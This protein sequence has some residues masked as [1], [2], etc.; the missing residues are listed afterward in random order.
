MPLTTDHLLLGPHKCHGSAL[1]LPKDCRPS[2]HPKATPSPAA[3][4][5]LLLLLLC[6]LVQL[7]HT[8]QGPPYA[9]SLSYVCPGVLT[10]LSEILGVP[11]SV[12]CPSCLFPPFLQLLL[13]LVCEGQ[14]F[15]L[16]C[17]VLHSQCLEQSLAYRRCSLKE[18]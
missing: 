1:C 12:L 4:H 18:C 14:G 8:L 16:L 3:L 11:L 15:H 9:S 17:A 7:Q 13:T 6:P 10:C 5:K 2:R